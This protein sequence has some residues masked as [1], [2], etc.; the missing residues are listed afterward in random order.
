MIPEARK[1]YEE[2]GIFTTDYYFG[3]GMMGKF[4]SE[5]KLRKYL[6]YIQKKEGKKVFSIELMCHPGFFLYNFLYIKHFCLIGYP[7][8]D[9]GDSFN[10]SLDRLHELEALS[11]SSFT[12]LY[13]SFN[14]YL[15]SYKEL[16]PKRNILKGFNLLVCSDFSPAS[17]NLIQ[18]QRL[19]P[20]F[21]T[22]GRVFFRNVYIIEKE[23]GEEFEKEVIGMK[24]LVGD[25][26]IQLIICFNVWKSG[27]FL[28][29]ILN[30]EKIGTV[31]I[32]LVLVIAGTDANVTLQV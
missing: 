32:P 20:F 9:F 28:R 27:R 23:E 31:E 25:L 5:E 10:R 19:K 3:H 17:G 7:S 12:S 4:F 11:S 14:L 16:L 18:C 2:N 29:R 6:E 1:I 15:G 30:R 8:E 24:R 26:G 22:F 21:M 13:Q